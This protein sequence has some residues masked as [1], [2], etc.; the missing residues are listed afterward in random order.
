[1]GFFDFSNDSSDDSEDYSENSSSGSNADD[2]GYDNSD[3]SD[4][5]NGSWDWNAIGDGAS[6]GIGI[7]SNLF[8]GSGSGGSGVSSKSQSNKGT[9]S[10]AGFDIG[11]LIGTIA[12]NV[13]KQLNK[14][15]A[16]YAKM[17]KNAINGGVSSWLGDH[18]V[19]IACGSGVLIAVIVAVAVHKHK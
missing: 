7:M 9:N 3:S 19:E 17:R 13:D 1:M 6:K 8:G 15:N 11:D 2:S 18:L 14:T 12:N 4:G 10:G 16:G 5:D